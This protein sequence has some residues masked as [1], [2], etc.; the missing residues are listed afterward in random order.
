[1]KNKNLILGI[2]ILGI[3]LMSSFAFAGITGGVITGKLIRGETAVAGGFQVSVLNVDRSGVANLQIT[4]PETKAVETVAVTSGGRVLTPFGEIKVG[5]VTTP[6]LFKRSSVKNIVVTPTTVSPASNINP[7][8][9]SITEEEC[10]ENCQA[11]TERYKLDEGETIS[12][13]GDT[14]SISF[15][16]ADSVSFEVNGQQTDL[17]SEN[18]WFELSNSQ[19]VEVEDIHRLEVGGEIGWVVL[20][21][22]GYKLD[23]GETITLQGNPI[24]IDFID[25]DEVRLNVN[26]QL[27]NLLI[28]DNTFELNNNQL[29]VV[30]N[31]AKLEVAGTTG[32]VRIGLASCYFPYF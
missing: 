11:F 26:N 13:G 2:F 14:I 21:L 24:S 29:A 31:I 9:T 15:I 8:I 1:M 28:K 32:Y 23:E 20:G 22:K 17:F 4:N 7:I 16:D 30:G 12:I 27:T 6:G 5:E 25:A 10:S 19:I 3:V 18:Q